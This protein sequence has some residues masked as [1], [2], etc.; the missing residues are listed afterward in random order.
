MSYHCLPWRVAQ[1]RSCSHG[2]SDGER[3]VSAVVDDDSEAVQLHD[4]YDHHHPFPYSDP[5]LNLNH[6]PERHVFHYPENL[7]G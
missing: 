4:R 2:D 7:Q 1:L 3:R 6:D 5:C